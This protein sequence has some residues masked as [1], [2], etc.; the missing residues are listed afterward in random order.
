MNIQLD[1]LA[2]NARRSI[3]HM[4]HGS[5][6]GHI[7]SSLSI[8]EIL[9]AAYST[10][11]LVAI[12]NQH[13]N[14]D[15]IIVS[16]GHAAC[17]AYA[18]MHQFGLLEQNLIDT[19]HKKG[20]LLQGHV[21]HGV[22]GVEH[23]TGALGHGLSVGVGHA[24]KL[25]SDNSNSKV[26]VICGDGEI[27]EGSIWEALMLASTKKLN[28]LIVIVDY[29]KISS[30]TE[31]EKVIHTGK[32]SKRFSGFGL[33]VEEVDGHD[34]NLIA[35]CINSSTENSSPL[36]LICH[37]VKGK[38]LSFTENQAIWHYR[39]LTDELFAQAMEELK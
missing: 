7:G 11:N 21:S 13:P 8:V 34:I 25:K 36:V 39:S 2:R 33:R 5:R 31:T 27:Q 24:L 10:S 4:I 18:V 9:V 14:R 35:S 15:R 1:A 6:A 26:I 3:V 37:T 20:S 23:S 22:Q 32:L 28:N 12:K 17:A 19:Y 38:G 16:K 30:F 29:N